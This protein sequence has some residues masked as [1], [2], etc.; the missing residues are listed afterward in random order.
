MTASHPPRIVVLGMMTKMPVAGVVWQNIHYLLGFQRLGYEPW[1]VEA[2]GI[3]PSMFQADENDDGSLAAANFIASVLRRFD[4]GDR[5]AYQALHHDGAC[6]GISRGELL[7]LYRSAELIIN[8]HGGTLPL[9]EHAATGRLI[10]LETDPVALQIEL[11]EGRQQTVDFLEPHSAFFTFGERYGLPGCG[12]P[13]ND[14][15]NFKPTRQPVVV[16]LWEGHGPPGDVFTTVGNF[17]QGWR[18]IQL[19]G[20]QYRWSKNWEWNKVLDLPG[21]TGQTFELAL[22]SYRHVDGVKLREHG[23]RIR[24]AAEVSDDVDVYRSYIAG[25]RGEFTVAKDQNIRLR[26]GWFS[27]RSATY[28]AAGRAVITQETGFSDLFP[29][30]EGLLAFSTVEEA[31]DAVQR[32]A[33]DPGLHGRAAV[34]IAREH[35][36]AEVVLKHLLSEVGL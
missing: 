29:T 18:E 28:L 16:D 26:T 11:H 23:W 31:A 19:G 27:D 22:A 24:P 30:G 25:S 10:Y 4:L 33:A 8:L 3:N 17:R 36:E 6:Y 15:F 2:H 7:D 21:R 14:R 35:F 20:E 34:T 5:W 9:P 32:V 1:Y 13:V 12:L